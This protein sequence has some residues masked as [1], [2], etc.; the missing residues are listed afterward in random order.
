M[1]RSRVWRSIR[2]RTIT[3]GTASCSIASDVVSFDGPNGPIP[4][5]AI[6]PVPGDGPQFDVLFDPQSAGG[7]YTLVVGPHISDLT[8]HELDEDAN[9]IGGEDPA[10]NYA[11]TFSIVTNV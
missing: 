11:A 7:S 4:V 6:N 5:L 2:W 3:G 9:G 8:G 10:D 1:A